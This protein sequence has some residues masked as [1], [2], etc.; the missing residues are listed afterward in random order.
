MTAQVYGDCW[1]WTASAYLPYPGFRPAAGAVGEYNGKFM[2]SQQCC[3]AAA[4]SRRRGHAT[5]DLPQLLPTVAR[6]GTS[7]ASDWP[8]THERADWT[9]G[10]ICDRHRP[11]RSTSASSTIRP[12]SV[13]P[14]TRRCGVRK[15]LSP[16]WFYDDHGSELFDEI[17]RL[18][19]Y[20]PTRAERSI[21]ERPRRTTSSRPGADTLVELGSGTS[22]K[23]RLLLDASATRTDC[24]GSCR[25]T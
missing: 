22:E 11:R 6:G 8:A 4:R 17:T 23:T 21:L 16:V 19:E 14:A 3:G 13:G 7:P 25:S 18:P 5:D 12:P 2:A 9:G 15:I 20:Y 10:S 24:A 1:E